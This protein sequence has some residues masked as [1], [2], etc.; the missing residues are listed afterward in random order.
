MT[1]SVIACAISRSCS[2]V[3]SCCRR[4][5]ITSTSHRTLP[6]IELCGPFGVSRR[7]RRRRGNDMDDVWVAP[8]PGSW[9]RD[10][11]HF[12]GALRGYLAA[13]FMP[14][15]AE[16]WRAGFARYGLPLESLQPA[17]VGGRMFARAQPVGAPEPKPRKSSA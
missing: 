2:P 15:F 11:V 12:E 3:R 16:G 7:R 17:M 9:I 10:D 5:A 4:S 6:P 8:G 14:A 1:T 13:L